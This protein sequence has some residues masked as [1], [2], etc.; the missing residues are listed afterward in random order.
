MVFNVVNE[1]ELIEDI[2]KYFNEKLDKLE[3]GL[4]NK[5]SQESLEQEAQATAY[6]KVFIAFMGNP[7]PDRIPNTRSWNWTSEILFTLIVKGVDNEREFIDYKNQIIS[8]MIYYNFK[9][10][11][12]DIGDSGSAVY[13]E[14]GSN[15]AIG[16]MVFYYPSELFA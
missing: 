14:S 2:V 12:M 3:C 8:L 16:E 15:L 7:K 4:T 6:G 13:A 1:F 10:V 9:N 5:R 11:L